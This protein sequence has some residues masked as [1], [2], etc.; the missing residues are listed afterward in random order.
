[1]I[2]SPLYRWITR[3]VRNATAC[4]VLL[5]ILGLCFR[6]S[7]HLDQRWKN[8]RQKRKKKTEKRQKDETPAVTW[9]LLPSVDVII[10]LP[11]MIYILTVGSDSGTHLFLNLGLISKINNKYDSVFLDLHWD[12][13]ISRLP[14]S[15]VIS[16]QKKNK[17]PECPLLS[18][19]V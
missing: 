5:K 17:K 8:G 7:Y 11:Y 12:T 19:L 3:R 13:H 16:G 10:I 18:L 2:V 1:M 14:I 4:S 15:A 6:Q 9:M